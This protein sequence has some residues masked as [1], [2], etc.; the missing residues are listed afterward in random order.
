M[1][2]PNSNNARFNTTHWSIIASSRDSDS[3]IRT[4]S[5]GELYQAYWYPLFA[6]LR[7]KG[8]S[9]EAAADYVQGFFVELID[10]DFLE[11]VAPEKGRFRWFMMSAVKRFVSKQTEKQN[12]QI[13]GGG[14]AIFSL[15]IDDAEQRYS[16]EPADGW[17]PEKLFDRRWALEVLS[18]ALAR[19][20]QSHEAAG[21]LELY[22]S[23]QSTLAGEAL[24]N[25]RSQQIGE[26]LGMSAVAV[27]VAAHR[28]K[29]K[30]RK[31]LTEIVSQTLTEPN[32]AA[33]VDEEL[34][35]LFQALHGE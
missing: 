20:R 11:S 27:K 24:T 35:S 9:P 26:Q 28:L 8:H 23:L 21:K 13:R 25:E 34:A 14:N 31:T 7:R 15:N 5:L 3:G 22:N 2:N 1:D 4:T 10:K 17:T 12:A 19:L 29:D 33:S 32:D 6:Y 30:Y 16:R 18:Q